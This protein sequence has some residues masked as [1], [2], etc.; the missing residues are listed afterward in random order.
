MS[1]KT[2]KTLYVAIAQIEHQVDGK[3]AYAE[4]N[5]TVA[6]SEDDAKVLLKAKAIRPLN[7]A[8]TELEALRAK[9][10][11][12]DAEKAAKPASKAAKGKEDKDSDI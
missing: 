10:A 4:P 2:A 7:E 9:S 5:S 8:E 6:L 3:R 11:A 1:T 12:D